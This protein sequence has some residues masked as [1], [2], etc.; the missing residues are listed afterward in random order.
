MYNQ[1]ISQYYQNMM[2]VVDVVRNGFVFS[3]AV[4]FGSWLRRKKSHNRKTAKQRKPQR[5]RA[6]EW[7]VMERNAS[8]ILGCKDECCHLMSFVYRYLSLVI[9]VNPSMY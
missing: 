7:S 2:F 6:T 8:E 3:A 5:R 1:V 4:P 9:L